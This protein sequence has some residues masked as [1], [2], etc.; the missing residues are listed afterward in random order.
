MVKFDLPTPPLEEEEAK[1]EKIRKSL[2]SIPVKNSV[3]VE[4]GIFSFY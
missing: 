1:E 2:F 4:D 3:P